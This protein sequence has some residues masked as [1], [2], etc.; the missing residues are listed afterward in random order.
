MNHATEGYDAVLEL[1]EHED[2]FV[3]QLGGFIGQYA[4]LARG[5][6]ESDFWKPQKKTGKVM[7]DQ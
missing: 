2:L 3:G 1:I 6:G 7:P 5:I 4:V